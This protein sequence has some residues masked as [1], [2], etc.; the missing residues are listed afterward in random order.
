M[1][2]RTSAFLLDTN[3][4]V[5]VYDTTDAAKRRQA[6]AVL[7]QVRLR[8]SGAL[9]VQVLGEFFVTVTRKIPVPLAAAQAERSVAN[10]VRSWTVYAL[11]PL[12]VLEAMRGVQRYQLSYWDCLIWATAKLNGVANVLS[13]DFN[14]GALLDGV[15]FLNPFGP[16]FD[17]IRL[18]HRP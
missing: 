10:Y 9:S 3:V 14:D 2:A 8:G 7:D 12:I 18:Q 6:I 5:Y 13:E 1:I 11:T 15:R 4:L 16:R 17:L